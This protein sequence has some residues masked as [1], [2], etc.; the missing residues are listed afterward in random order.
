MVEP[1]QKG[2]RPVFSGEELKR[3]RN[4][5]KLIGQFRKQVLE[6]M[7]NEKGRADLIDLLKE[8]KEHFDNVNWGLIN[9]IDAADI[10]EDSKRF[11]NGVAHDIVPHYPTT[12]ELFTHPKITPLVIARAKRVLERK[13]PKKQ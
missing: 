1:E 9:A 11:I 5:P 8:H 7:K 3:I 4:T 12:R 2:K 10:L 6:A 13:F